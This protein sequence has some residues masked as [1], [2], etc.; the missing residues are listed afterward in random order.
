MYYEK[1]FRNASDKS[2]FVSTLRLHGSC[3]PWRTWEVSSVRLERWPYKPCVVGSTPSFP[4]SRVIC[5]QL[6]TFRA[7]EGESTKNV[8]PYDD[9]CTIVGS[10]P[11]CGFLIN[12]LGHFFHSRLNPFLPVTDN[13]NNIIYA[14]STPVHRF[15]V[16]KMDDQI[17]FPFVR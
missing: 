1:V 8:R 17:S 10:A 15:S 3:M 6:D 4:I 5:F 7:A 9:L 14:G 2:S 11:T 13:I 16:V 12:N